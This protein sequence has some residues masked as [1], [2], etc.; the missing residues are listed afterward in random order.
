MTLGFIVVVFFFVEIE[1]E[2]E[3]LGPLEVGA[4]LHG[5]DLA[6]KEELVGGG[7]GSGG[8]G[9][10]RGESGGEFELE[11]AGD[12]GVGGVGREAASA[13]AGGG[14]DEVHGAG[15]GAKEVTTG[16]AAAAG[17]GGGADVGSGAEAVDIVRGEAQGGEGRV[18]VVFAM[19]G[20]CELGARRV[21]G[22]PFSLSLS[23][24]L[25]LSVDYSF[26]EK[27]L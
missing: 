21:L 15:G 1:E 27:I 26:S 9:G 12:G 2:G 19:V 23:L 20:F 25:F 16:D 11:G 24:S 18:E 10:S 3:D 17:A 22:A 7:H 6:V 4:E 8:E 5:A 14:E 13:A